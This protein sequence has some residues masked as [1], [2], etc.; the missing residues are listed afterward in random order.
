MKPSLRWD[1]A[2]YGQLRQAL[3]PGGGLGLFTARVL[4]EF[5]P[6]PLGGAVLFL[7]ACIGLCLGVGATWRL[8][9][10]G[11]IT[12]PL[13]FLWGYVLWPWP[14]LSLALGLLIAT[15]GI[16]LWVNPPCR[17]RPAWVG[18][19]LFVAFFVLYLLTLAP[20]VLP[21]DS[22]EFQLVS[23]LLGIAHPPGYALYTLLG[24]LFTLLPIGEIAYRVNL[25]A[26]IT[27]A[28][29]LGV[30]ATSLY[31]ETG[32]TVAALVAAA[33][34]GLAPT[35]WVQ[36]TTANIRS[37][38]ALFTAL[39]LALLL[40]WGATRQRR[41]LVLF[42]LCFGLGVGHHASLGLLGLPFLFYILAHEPHLPLEPRR[43]LGA[44]GAAIGAQVVL[45]YLPLRSYLGAPFGTPVRTWEQF[46]HHVLALGFRGDM[47][48]Y[49]T[50]AELAPRLGIWGQIVRLQ[51]GLPL[52]AAFL[53]AAIWLG[54]RRWRVLLLLAGTWAMNTLAAITYRA[55][56]T[57]EY[58]IPS[59]VALAALLGYGL[60]LALR[61][62]K[63]GTFAR[64][65]A[66]GAFLFL[67][68]WRGMMTYPE[69][70]S[71][72]RDT[73]AQDYASTIL[74]RAPPSAL[75]LSNWHY[76]TVFW[77]LQRIDGLRPDVQVR[78][79]YPEGAKPYAESWLAHIA[80]GLEEGRDVIV[81]NHY[82]AFDDSPYRFY[83]LGKGWLVRREGLSELPAEAERLSATFGDCIQLEGLSLETRMLSPGEN[84]QLCLYWRPLHSLTRNYTAFVQLLGPR[85]VVGQGDI[86]HRAAACPPGELQ[87]DAFRFPI[88]LHTS[89]GTYRLIAG[90]YY[91]TEEGWKRLPVAGQDYLDLGEIQ[92]QPAQRVPA[93]LHPWE[94]LFSQGLVL[95]GVDFD[96]S[97]KGS[98]RVYLH[99]Q[100]I[101][102]SNRAGPWRVSLAQGERT[103]ASAVLG[104]L[105]PKGTGTLALDVPVGA[106]RLLLQVRD[107]QGNLLSP[108]GPWHR[109]RGTF[110][111]LVLPQGE[112]RYVP[113]GGEMAFLGLQNPVSRA[114]CG[115]ALWLCPRF[116][117][118]HSL[119]GDYTVS[120]GITQDG[121]W[122][123]KA[124][125]TPALGAIPT[126]KWLGG[127]RV[128]DPHCL[129]LQ[130]ATE[131]PAQISLSVYNAFTLEPLPVL[132][133]RLV[134]QGQGIYLHLGE[135]KIQ[136][137]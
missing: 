136:G 132:D 51:F 135:V 29:T 9:R 92:V 98:M 38:T 72:N 49:R 60:G 79:V 117:A 104:P 18:S 113:L 54:S 15:G 19:G 133:E 94:R 77:Y 131:G 137:P 4:V 101:A 100:R 34:L 106:R 75:I 8:I 115:K 87:A 35:F 78:Y 80:K 69:I 7:L 103:L 93:T 36:S 81:T 50:W 122:E 31:Y 62:P 17:L 95:R 44:L 12:W 130:G 6:Q 105:P 13:A 41:T 25:F 74:R 3:L 63:V 121:G 33:S 39:C 2:L 127:W 96:T 26:A 42:G 30:L 118:L 91:T 45:L 86:S 110:L 28:L 90:F 83:P 119:T 70:H 102:N 55:P 109:P 58:L 116:L 61:Y 27:G 129:S 73:S 14:N 125:G 48:H 99:W 16:F 108:L 123:V 53:I 32:S 88:L 43:W 84:V 56:Q 22:G 124:D 67:L 107:E 46:L 37:L 1:S 76:A 82:Y 68:S 10:W 59:Y 112:P 65:V 57:V 52:L 85:G 66:V 128:K 71:L 40:R 24:K 89:P 134:R 5:L 114:A 20:G 11:K 47:F 126:L 111:E 120:V 21:A 64:G 23:Y 97:I